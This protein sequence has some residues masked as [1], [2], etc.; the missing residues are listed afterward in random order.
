MNAGSK[1]GPW[2]AEVPNPPVAA[3]L[4][5]FCVPPVGMGGASF[6][7]WASRILVVRFLCLTNVSQAT[8]VIRGA[9]KQL[10]PSVELLAL[11][12]PGRG[13]RMAEPMTCHSLVTLAQEAIDGIGADAPGWC[14]QGL[15][16]WVG[17]LVRQLDG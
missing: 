5:L 16:G 3:K 10:P 11:E 13:C 8:V 6:H 4:R 12:L 14:R 7:P 1:Y 15:V 17:W 9:A 2:I